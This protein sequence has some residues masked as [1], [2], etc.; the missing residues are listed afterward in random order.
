[1][2]GDCVAWISRESNNYPIE[3]HTSRGDTERERERAAY[4]RLI[5][6]HQIG[7]FI[8][9]YNSQ[10]ISEWN[11]FSNGF[12]ISPCVCVRAHMCN[13]C[14][15]RAMRTD[16]IEY[17]SFADQL[18]VEFYTRRPWTTKPREEK[19]THFYDC[20]PKSRN[21]RNDILFTGDSGD[22]GD[23][24]DGDNYGQ[25]HACVSILFFLLFHICNLDLY[26]RCWW[27]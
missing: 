18:L 25:Q 22:G 4:A 16:S 12:W 17:I 1:M 10:Q 6:H 11:E 7:A 21:I 9:N 13:V 24:G 15:L 8:F 27:A 19:K 14:I 20:I 23:G 2:R 5:C 3:T 26:T